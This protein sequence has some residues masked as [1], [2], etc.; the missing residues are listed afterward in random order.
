MSITNANLVILD[1]SPAD[2]DDYHAAEEKRVKG[3]PQQTTWNYFSDNSN[4]F[5][6]GVWQGEVGCWKV[7]YTEFEYCEILEGKSILRDSDGN[8]QVLEVGTKFVIPAGFEGEWEV[9][10]TC[11]KIYVIFESNTP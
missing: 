5:H 9:L 1:Q 6:T 11:K 8:E 10:E 2:R 3:N 4:Q 7:S